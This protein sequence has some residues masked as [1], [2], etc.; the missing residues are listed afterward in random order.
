MTAC[1]GCGFELRPDFAFCPRCGAV[2]PEPCAAC[3]FSCQPDFRFCPKCGTARGTPPAPAA[4]NRPEPAPS[5]HR[6]DPA[7]QLVEQAAPGAPDADRRPVT[8]L[9][10]DLSGFTALGTRLDPEDVRALQTD[11]FQ[12][13][14]AAIESY[15]G[16]VEKYVGDAVMAVFGAPVAHEDDPERAL[17]AALAMHERTSALSRR[18]ERRLGQPIALHVG[19]NTGPVV[20][21]NLGAMAG[22]AYA[23]TGDTVNTASRLQNA[24]GS[25]ETLVSRATHHLTRHAFA[26]DPLPELSVKGKVE[27]LVVYRLRACLRAPRG[28]RGLETYGLAAPLVGRDA[29]LDQLLVA[30]GRMLDGHA[31]VVSLIGD[32]GS[33]KSRLVREF[34]G[35]LEARGRLA[36]ITVRQ[37]ACSSLG[38]QTY[39]VLAASIRQGY[40]VGP[41]DTLETARAKV[42]A[43]VQ[44]L[45]GTEEELASIGALIGH[46]LGFDS[47]SEP[48]ADADPERLKRRIFLATRILFERRL[49]HV[50]LLV[51]V[52]DLQWADAASIEVLRFVVDRL[53]D[54]RL[55]LVATYRPSF[56]GASLVSGRASHTGLRLGPLSAEDS[57]RILRAL[58]GASLERWPPALRE[59]VETRAGGNPLFL[60]EVIRGLIEAG[61]LVQEGTGWRC[62]ADAQSIDVPPT[63]QALLLARFDRLPPPARRLLQEAAVL[64]PVFDAR[65]LRLVASE[66]EEC[67]LGLESLVGAEL[68]EEMA[69]TGVTER[70]YR[71]SHALVQEVVYQNLLQRRRVELHGR[72]GRSLER[73]CGGAPERLEDLEMLGRHFRSSAE[74]VRGAR[75]LIAAGERARV[76][77]AN[78][79]AIRHYEQ[80]LETLAECAGCEPE[81][82]LVHERL[83]DLLRHAGAGEAAL[84]HYEAALASLAAGG[85]RPGQ[86]RL[87]RSIGSL[88]WTAGDRERALASC[89]AGLALLEGQER[90]IEHAHLCQEMGR[91]SFRAGDNRGAVE[92]AERALAHAET[93]A[94]G[95]DDEASAA[96]DSRTDVMAA[97]A[98]AYNTLGIA[99]A[100]LGRPAEAVAH[101]ERSVAVA[102]AEGLLGA[103]CRSYS[104]LGVLYSTLDPARAIRTCERGLEIARKT[105]DV[106]FQSRFYANLA[107]AYCALTNRCDQEGIGAAQTAIELDRR[108][109]QLD[110][111]AVPLI[112]L[113]QIYQCHGEPRLALERFQEAME[114]AEQTGDPQLLFPCY[115]GLAA[116]YLELGDDGRADEYMRRAQQV[117]ERTGVDAESL[118]VLPFLE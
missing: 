80:A 36:A 4:S 113:A 114:L 71:F 115:D 23:V 40:A 58:F 76:I 63:I 77:Y 99:L 47:A 105:G 96:G 19:V 59:L 17:R 95:L 109:G 69:S 25:G 28:A 81:R 11:L 72:A 111:L 30:F 21:G 65:L 35:A 62:R 14:T 8:V 52:E 79:D 45:G 106:G 32:A 7:L 18:W 90:H 86:A 41:E 110:H 29:E 74:R 48:A 66:P 55:M 98:H 70:R 24:A 39:G 93:L 68:L 1:N 54:R 91:M 100:R 27:P 89:A 2:L 20:A 103:A 88:R 44:R 34:L 53:T 102:A 12:E 10:A 50:P 43:G 117:C 116:L 64:G 15:G 84:A 73:L 42:T 104:N 37:T 112:V 49:E 31:Q 60:E 5:T 101:I 97:V 46:V 118:M 16:F 85:D 75:Y 56:D 108:L 22:A 9:F 78:Q 82:Q 87:H 38:E 33:G 92:W 94:A 26:F 61:V 51:I 57:E 67:D 107:V 6:P 83:G 3:G 13:L